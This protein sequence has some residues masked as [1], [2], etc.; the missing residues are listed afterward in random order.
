M[1]RVGEFLSKPP[2]HPGRISYLVGAIFFGAVLV[3][4]GVF[5][6]LHAS[7]FNWSS[8]IFFVLGATQLGVIGE[9]LPVGM[10]RATVA[11]RTIG[12]CMMLLFFVGS[13]VWMLY[14]V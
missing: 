10:N 7:R 11:L 5:T 3:A 12:F 13:L 8:A 6:D 1:N 2:R 14:L 4:L 9:V